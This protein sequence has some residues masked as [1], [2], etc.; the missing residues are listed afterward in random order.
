MPRH[1]RIVPPDCPIHVTHRGNRR[2]P[3]F[4]GGGAQ[5]RY[6]S[7]LHAETQRFGV[8]VWAYCLMPNHVHLIVVAREAQALSK[9]MHRAHG[10]Y[11]QW[12]NA[13]Q[14][15]SGHLWSSRF[16]STPMD[17]AHLWAAVRYVECNPVRAGL[18]G[19]AEDHVWSSARAHV[20]RFADPLLAPSRPFPGHIEN[21][22]AWLTADPDRTLEANIRERT[23]M[24]VPAGDATFLAQL[25]RETGRK[26]SPGTRGRLVAP[27]P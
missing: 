7:L 14:G 9:A 20:M 24:G 2:A 3:I 26:L 1:A 19:R 6:L 4:V 16:F 13:H 8:E 23:S 21:W 15:W 18:V 5:R 25:E 11:A 27:N 10:Q 22:S 12:I 17:D